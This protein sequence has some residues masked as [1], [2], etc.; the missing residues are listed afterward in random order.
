[1]SMSMSFR[2]SALALAATVAGM[3]SCAWAAP[4][5][6][7]VY[8]T[9]FTAGAIGR[10]NVDGTG[11]TQSF[12]TGPKNPSGVA[13]DGQHVYWTNYAAG[14]IGR[15][16]LDGSGANPNFITGLFQPYG[17]AVDGQH[18][19]WTD[20]WVNSI[21]RANLDGSGAIPLFC[22]TGV[23]TPRGVAVDG[24]HLY[25]TSKDLGTIGRLNLDG[26]AVNQSFITG[27]TQPLGV[28]VDGQHVYWTNNGGTTIAR[29][30]L[31]GTGANQS[32]ITGLDH[33]AGLAVHG[34]YLYWTNNN[35]T[36]IGRAKLDGSGANQSFITGA[37][38]PSG[39]AVD[40]PT[41]GT[42]SVGGL[43]SLEFGTQPQGVLGAP[44]SLA[45][46]NTGYGNLQIDKAR[47]GSGDLDDF[48]ITY[49]SCSATTVAPG[50]ACRLN[51]RFA[52]SAAGDRHATLTLTS[53]DP[54][55]PLQLQLNGT[56][57]DV[58]AGPPG[59]AG[60][61]GATGAAGAT[62]A[63]GSGG[64]TGA[65]GATGAQ[66]PPGQIR[67]VTCET[68]KV[69]SHGRRV[70]RRRCTTRLITGPATFTTTGT[71]RASLTRNGVSFATGTASNGRAVLRA[72]RPLRR[73]RYT[74]TVRSVKHGHRVTTRTPVTIR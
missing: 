12:V 55:G 31:D 25:W 47:V 18:V 44:R 74:L 63:T 67:L 4:A 58:L 62:G 38:H 13:V 3:V 52:P 7:H 19:Y 73:G 57:G 21:G 60:A 15:A 26:T 11:P 45:I 43:L 20:A 39:V 61:T 30:N 42:A 23:T 66:G 51:L 59:P 34:L 35:S 1:M 36:T 49:D 40:G 54:K 9:N 6:A 28:A 71:A 29:A 24:Q 37:D 2:R 17:V 56:A 72:H 16:N 48:L 70:K 33:P 46:T 64:A 41:N 14:S 65:T 8:W 5:G 27:A 69:K 22:C 53:D 32:F 50:D 68:V 10:A